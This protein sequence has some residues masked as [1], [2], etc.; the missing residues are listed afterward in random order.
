MND[1]QN[2][3]NFMNQLTDWVMPGNSIS[4]WYRNEE[5]FRYSSGYADL[6]NKIPMTGEEYINIYSCSKVA[7][8]TAALQLVE[9]GRIL[10]TD[11]LY[12]YIPAYRHMTVREADGTL[13]P[14]KTPITL[15]HLFTM[16]AGFNYNC[17]TPA[18]EKAKK[19][20][21]G[22]METLTVASCLAEEPLSF[23]PGMHWQY[24]LCHDV[25]AAVVEVVSGMR[26]CEYMQKNVF[27]PAGITK[28]CYHHTPEVLSHM[29]QQ[30][31]LE[32]EEDFDPVAAQSGHSKQ[33]TGTIRNVGLENSFAFGALYDSGGAGITTTVNEY[34]KLADALA[35]GGRAA[36]GE[37][38]LAT[39]TVALLQKNALSS[40]V[41]PDI[42]WGNLHG[43]GYGLGVRT[44]LDPTAASYCGTGGEI[45]WGGAAGATLSADPQTGLSFFYA[46]HMLNP[47][48]AYYQPRIRN[49][50]YA[51]Y[52]KRTGK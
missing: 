18:F 39:G 45:G 28:V 40:S 15:Y 41:L 5:I 51:D 19:L 14:A 29:A 25:L 35:C 16:T 21:D 8:V 9:R 23:D 44:L 32:T 42:D 3:K 49:A 4:V 36:T 24:S 17:H 43:Y 10:L 27:E 11:P 20:T 46:H 1:F 38:I 31:I 26:F 52:Q 2:V 48:E 7:T 22:R 37:Q 47:Q 6:E 30:Y 34:A 33:G 50:V 12:E 13:R